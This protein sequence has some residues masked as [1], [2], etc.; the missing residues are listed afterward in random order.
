[1]P[2]HVLEQMHK[3]TLTPTHSYTRMYTF[4]HV[5]SVKYMVSFKAEEIPF[6]STGLSIPI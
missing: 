3:F 1:M 4:I 6:E 2:L 5:L